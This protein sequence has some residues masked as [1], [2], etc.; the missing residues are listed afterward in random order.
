MINPES[1]Y[2]KK[3]YWYNKKIKKK[4]VP[5]P[6]QSIKIR[7]FGGY[8][9]LLDFLSMKKKNIQRLSYEKEGKWKFVC[10]IRNA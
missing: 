9:C 8:I 5:K 1:V 3:I 7:L 6:L 4:K 10:L 2:I